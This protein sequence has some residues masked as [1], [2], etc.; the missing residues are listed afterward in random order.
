MEKKPGREELVYSWG[1]NRFLEPYRPRQRRV[2]EEAGTHGIRCGLGIPVHGPMGSCGVFLLS[3]GDPEWL[4][5]TTEGEQDQLSA[6]RV[7][8]CAGQT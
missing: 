5:R 8:P 4:R 7:I 1:P 6:D 3:D 2:L